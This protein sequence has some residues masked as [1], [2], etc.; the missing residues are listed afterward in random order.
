MDKIKVLIKE[1]LKT[2]YG[3]Y[4]PN[5]LEAKQKIVGGLIECVPFDNYVD[6]I[7]NE[8]GKLK[9]LTPNLLL[10]KDYVAGTILF[11]RVDHKKGEFISL[12]D[13]DVVNVF[14]FVMNIK[15]ENEDIENEYFERMI[16][17]IRN[18]LGL[19]E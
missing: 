17:R 11:A 9:N 10:D 7:C 19:F 1:P 13:D 6:M 4:I 16:E 14:M 3:K 18:R 12:T 8:E 15:L 2:I 5:T